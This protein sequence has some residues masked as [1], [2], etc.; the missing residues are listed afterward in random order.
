M[1]DDLKTKAASAA[2][3]SLATEV[4]VKLV[5]PVTQMLLARILAPEAFGVV[6][7][8]TMVVSFAEM[9]A[10]SGFQKYLVQHEFVDE[11][12]LSRSSCVAFW[13]NLALA[14]W[15]LV[16]AFRDPL[17]A[18]VGSPGLGVALAVA[19]ASLPMQALSSIQTALFRRSFD[20]RSMMP[21]RVATALVPLGV[22]LPLALAG[23]GFWSL[24]IGTLCGNLLSAVALTALSPWKPRPFYSFSLLR[25]MFSFSGWSLLEAVSIWL[26]SW[27][28]IFV[29]GSVL[30]EREL[31][32][33]RTPMGLVNSAMA[34]VTGATTPVL[35]SSLSRLQGDPAGFRAFFSSFQARVA[36]FVLPLGVGIFLFRDFVTELLLGPQWGEASLMVGLWGLSSGVLIVFSHYCSEVYRA[37]GRPRVS[38]LSQCLY[39]AVM[40]PVRWLSAREGFQCLVVASAAVRLWGV[41]VN[42]A[43]C[44]R[45]AGIGL[46]SVLRNVRAPLLS[47]LAM[48]AAGWPVAQASSGSWLWSAAGVVS[49]AGFYAAALCA[50]PEGRSFLGGLA[51]PILSRVRRFRAK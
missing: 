7:T 10:D 50:F 18:L 24:I 5:S 16:A 9:L 38:L 36:A 23:L 14:L 39:L 1:A 47:S 37:M 30:G 48:F 49:C 6:A 19:C 44:K 29:V 31:G 12:E 35:Y 33:Y 3:W 45:L 2:K 34:L 28:G 13:S 21:V 40:V 27:A 15:G 43:L 32:L 46:L 11:G 26:T 22:T 4:A 51:T 25:E 8:V 41:V 17:S 20:F 42:Q